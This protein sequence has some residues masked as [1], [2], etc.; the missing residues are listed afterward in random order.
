MKVRLKSAPT[1]DVHGFTFGEQRTVGFAQDL[2]AKVQ[3]RSR[4]FISEVR[5]IIASS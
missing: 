5:T 3:Q 1:D 4:T 2:V